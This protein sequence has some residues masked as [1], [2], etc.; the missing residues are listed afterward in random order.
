MS[1]RSDRSIREQAVEH[2]MIEPF[3]EKQVREGVISY[4]LSF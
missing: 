3:G 4:G 2:R 1:I